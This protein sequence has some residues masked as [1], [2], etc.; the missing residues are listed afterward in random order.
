MK[1]KSFVQISG[2]E[3]NC[4]WEVRLEVGEKGKFRTR[5]EH[6]RLRKQGIKTGKD[7][8]KRNIRDSDRSWVY[9]NIPSLIAWKTEIHHDWNDGGR[10]YLLTKGEHIL[11]HRSDKERVDAMKSKKVK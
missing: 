10:M 9:R 3:E 6:F 4:S 11:R 7:R 1:S 5:G 8:N 2:S